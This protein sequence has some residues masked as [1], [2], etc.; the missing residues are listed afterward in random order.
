LNDQVLPPAS[1]VYGSMAVRT[2]LQDV[3]ARRDSVDILI[4]GDSNTNFGGWGWVDG[5]NWALQNNTTA[6]EYG[7]PIVPC[8]SW[9]TAFYYGVYMNEAAFSKINASG[10]VVNAGGVGALGNTLVSGITSGPSDLTNAMTRGSGSLQ[11]NTSPFD[12]G[13][14]AGSTDWSDTLGGI[15]AYENTGRLTWI[16]NALQYRVVHGK[17]PSMGTLRL[18]ARLDAA[19]F[20]AIGTQSISCAQ[21][22][23]EW[24]TS[25]LSI[26]ANSSRVGNQYAFYYAS[27]NVSSSR[28]TGPMAV[29]MHSLSRTEVKGYSV[30]SISHH[31]GASMDTIVSNVSQA[32]T[33]IRQYLK[34]AR[35]RQIASGGSGRVIVAIQ[36]GINAGTNSWATSASSFFTTC[37]TE[38]AALGYPSAD[39][40]C[41]GWVSHQT[42]SSDTLTTERASSISL[43]NGGSCTIVDTTAFVSY[44]DI[45]TGGGS[46]TTWYD[47][48]GNSH[49]TA[50]GYQS[51][52]SRMIAALLT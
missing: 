42:A 11:P 50:A 38:W 8:V 27:N 41:L 20:T 49:L 7:T 2:M 44:N 26:A 32:S 52:G 16:G 24:V 22:S 19:P 18:S 10:T 48:G 46:G 51:I 17:G 43:G 30:T 21:A 4:A 1:G 14:W 36:G 9:D 47:S 33:I 45:N 15:F 40:A 3:V 37:R 29:A 5:I 13:W 39:L 34:E 12:Y 35:N 25:T 28:L 31:G 6:I 23:Y